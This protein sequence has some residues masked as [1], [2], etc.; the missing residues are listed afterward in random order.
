MNKSRTFSPEVGKRA[1]RMVRE[2][3][4]EDPSLWVAVESVSPKIGSVPQ[5]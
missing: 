1:V 3:R 2:H 5:A 4:G